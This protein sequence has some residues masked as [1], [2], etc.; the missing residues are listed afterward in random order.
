MSSSG[1]LPDSLAQD[2]RGRAPR[3]VSILCLVLAFAVGG[4]LASAPAS[5][6]TT[7]RAA[8]WVTGAVQRDG[9]LTVTGWAY[10]PALPASEVSVGLWV[11]GRYEGSHRT[12]VYSSLANTNHHLT[13]D[14][15]FVFSFHLVPRATRVTVWVLSPRTE[16]PY[17]TVLHADTPGYRIIQQA[18]RY[19]GYPYVEGGASPSSGFDCSGYTRYVYYTAGVKSLVHNAQGQRE[20]MKAISRASAR[21][22][23]LIFYLSGGTAYHVAIYA[24]GN[25]QYAATTPGE[26]VKYQGI[27]SSNVTFGTDWH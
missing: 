14:H 22:G 16:L 18:K 15:G 11:D 20:E 9:Y 19:V 17:R 1:S 26:G 23:D 7:A 24:G 12:T 27:W 13:G 4:V 3:F 5:A 21:P 8:G 10:N 25:M 6:S 2:R